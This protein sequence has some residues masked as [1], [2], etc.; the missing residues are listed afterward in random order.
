MAG[1]FY[2]RHPSKDSPKN[3]QAN[4][5]TGGIWS[6]S[7]CPAICPPILR[8]SLARRRRPFRQPFFGHFQFR[9]HR[10]SVAVPRGSQPWGSYREK[11]L[12]NYSPHR[13]NYRP[14]FY[15]FSN[16]SGSKLP[17]VTL[18]ENIFWKLLACRV[19]AVFA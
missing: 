10:Q 4:G 6:F 1:V 14:D 2:P 18:P 3:G 7:A 19:F 17:T 16:E 15:D 9:A 11:I 5:R 8:L 12:L 13:Q